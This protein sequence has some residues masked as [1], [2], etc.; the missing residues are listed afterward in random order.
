MRGGRYGSGPRAERS[1]KRRTHPDA[2]SPASPCWRRRRPRRPPWP[3]TDR[4]PPPAPRSGSD[5][6]KAFTKKYGE[7]RSMQTC[8]RRTRAKVRRRPA[9][10]P[11]GVRRASCGGSARRVRRGLR[12]RRVGLG[13]E[14]NCI[15]DTTALILEPVDEV[16]RRG[17]GIAPRRRSGARPKLSVA[18]RVAQLVEHRFCKPEAAGSSPAPG[19]MPRDRTMPES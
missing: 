13:R 19:F 16:G 4:P 14:A 2:P 5:R 15:A 18:A 6:R 17:R 11:S 1:M 12:L 7:R 10:R 3:W 9:A 8:I